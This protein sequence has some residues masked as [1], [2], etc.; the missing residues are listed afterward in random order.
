M[1]DQV[2]VL[3]KRVNDLTNMIESKK[4]EQLEKVVHALTRKVLS[5]EDQVKVIK[6]KK[7]TDQEEIKEK[8]FTRESSFNHEDIM[9]STPKDLKEKVKDKNEEDLFKC[10]ECKYKCKK[11]TTFKKHMITNHSHHKCKECHQN[12]P[13]FMELLKHVAKHHC[14]EQNDKNDEKF[15]DDVSVQSE[16]KD[17]EPK[18]NH[19]E[20]ALVDDILLKYLEE[21]EEYQKD[22]SFEFR[23]SMLDDYLDNKEK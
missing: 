8:C 10:K 23:E 13:S 7:E 6:N 1:K 20:D 11:E 16:N 2:E 22:L 14:K 18:L 17:K 15:K 5:L 9:S 21:K 3:E 4:L 19:E 12:M